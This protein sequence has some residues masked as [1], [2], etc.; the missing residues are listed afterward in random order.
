MVSGQWLDLAPNQF[1]LDPSRLAASLADIRQDPQHALLDL[2]ATYL[3]FSNNS[4]SFLLCQGL[5]GMEPISKTGFTEGALTTHKIIREAGVDG[6]TMPTVSQRVTSLVAQEMIDVLRI[7]RATNPNTDISTLTRRRWNDEAEKEP[8][9]L[10]A[11][12]PLTEYRTDQDG[13]FAG[14]GTTIATLRFALAETQ[15]NQAQ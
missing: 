6:G 4:F 11:L 12:L 8:S 2:E 7:T 14:A 13:Y 15:D 9:V 10:D 1:E 5:E 3:E